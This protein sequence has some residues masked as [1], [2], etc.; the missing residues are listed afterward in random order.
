MKL[1]VYP[2]NQKNKQNIFKISFLDF[3]ALLKLHYF[4]ANE[5]PKMVNIVLHFAF[6]RVNL[7]VGTIT[8]WIPGIMQMKLFQ[9]NAK[10][11]KILYS[12]FKRKRKKKESFHFR[13]EPEYLN[14]R[15]KI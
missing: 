1:Q 10:L 9:I 2:F 12:G 8:F 6:V 15:F 13:D 4:E 5:N 14:V 3:V 7:E 11:S